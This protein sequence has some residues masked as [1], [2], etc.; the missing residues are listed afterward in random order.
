MVT[1]T[2]DCAVLVVRRIL[3]FGGGAQ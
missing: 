2:V 3:E 1:E